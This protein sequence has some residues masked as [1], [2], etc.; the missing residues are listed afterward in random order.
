MAEAM[1]VESAEV[2]ARF[3]AA[4]LNPLPWREVGDAACQQVVHREIDLNKLLPIPTHNE[5]DSG[6]YI[7]AGLLITRNPR[8]GVQNVSIHRL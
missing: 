6:P 2:L 5:H 7:T 1:G 8:T 3:E 4:S